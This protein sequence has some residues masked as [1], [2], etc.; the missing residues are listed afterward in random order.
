MYL[1]ICVKMLLDLF[2][3]FFFVYM[4]NV[5][6]FLIG[7]CNLNVIFLVLVF[8]IVYLISF[9]FL[10]FLVLLLEIILNVRW[11]CLDFG[12]FS[13][14]IDFLVL[15]IYVSLWFR[16]FIFKVKKWGVIIG[17]L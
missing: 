14:M 10:Y 13:L 9:M 7:K 8:N 4:I 11:S 16:R 12:Y 17:M 5:Y 1:Y 2:G 3:L 6:F 15:C